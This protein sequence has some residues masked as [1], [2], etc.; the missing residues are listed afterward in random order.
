MLT[1]STTQ[2]QLFTKARTHHA[3]LDRT[4]SDEVLKE[5][6]ELAKWGTY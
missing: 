4:V 2:E 1:A 3:W 6:Y 5:I